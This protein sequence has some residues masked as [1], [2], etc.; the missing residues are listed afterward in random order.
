MEP[1]RN[2]FVSGERGSLAGEVDEDV[3]GD[4]L[5][6]AGVSDLS[7]R[8]GEDQTHM[9]TDQGTEGRFRSFRSVGSHQIA[10]GRRGRGGHFTTILPPP[11][12]TGHRS[13]E[14]PSPTKKRAPVRVRAW[15]RNVDD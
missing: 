15:K 8:G 5:G 2:G 7:Q 6:K 14:R 4:F 12:Q 11:L 13:L 10:V 3:L 9:P 1:S